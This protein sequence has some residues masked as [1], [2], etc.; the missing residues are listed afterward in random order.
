MSHCIEHLDYHCSTSEKAILKDI[1]RWAYDPQESSGYHGD[2]TFHKEPVYKN[3]E[4]A[5]AAIKNFDRGWYSDHAVRYR[6]GRKIY[7][8]VK[9]EWHC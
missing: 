1:N 6:N 5:M 9:V 4:E 2:L 3:R 7:W 8:L